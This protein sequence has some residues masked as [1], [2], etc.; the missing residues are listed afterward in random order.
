MRRDDERVLRQI[1][2]W[3]IGASLARH[4]RD[5]EDFPC[6]VPVLD[7]EMR[8][9]CPALGFGTLAVLAIGF[10]AVETRL[11]GRDSFRLRDVLLVEP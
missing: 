2:D 7:E 10:A 8:C 4:L 5:E 1:A 9:R 11:Q 6:L 3:E